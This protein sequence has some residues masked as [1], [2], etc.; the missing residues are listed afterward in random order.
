MNIQNFANTLETPFI[1]F[2]AN[3]EYDE[4]KRKYIIRAR[5]YTD[6]TFENAPADDDTKDFETNQILFQIPKTY[7]VIVA[8]DEA[9]YNKVKGLRNSKNLYNINGITKTFHRLSLGRHTKNIVFSS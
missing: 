5:G 8:D 4:E 1:R 6:F 9:I 2:Q 3:Y 7:T